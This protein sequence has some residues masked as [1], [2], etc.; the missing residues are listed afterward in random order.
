MI[1]AQLTAVARILRLPELDV[2]LARLLIL[3]LA[4]V[5]EALLAE[6]VAA[7]AVCSAVVVAQDM[8][9]VMA[10]SSYFLH[11]PK[12]AVHLLSCVVMALAL[13]PV[14]QLFREC[15]VLFSFGPSQHPQA[16]DTFVLEDPNDFPTQV[17]V[18]LMKL[19]TRLL[20]RL[21]KVV[22]G[23]GK[24]A[25]LLQYRNVMRLSPPSLCFSYQDLFTSISQSKSV[26][27]RF[28]S[29]TAPWLP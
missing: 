12:A 21:I 5:M 27:V 20:H 11:T 19:V 16:S 25:V 6:R 8:I 22:L 14:L 4:A 1:S 13:L 17:P 26:L 18:S 3:V 9:A 23:C 2:E 15:A 7:L 24:L 28:C 10:S 29:C